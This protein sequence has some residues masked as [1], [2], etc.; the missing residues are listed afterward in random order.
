[1]GR[2]SHLE[3]EKNKAGHRR[4]LQDIGV[5]GKAFTTGSNHQLV[6]A[7]IAI[8]VKVEKRAL[9]TSNKGQQKTTL[10]SRTF[11]KLVEEEDWS[12]KDDISDDYNSLVDHLR[13]MQQMA[14]LPRANH[15]TKQI[16][17]A[18]KTLLEK[19]RQMKQ[20]GKDHI[21]YSLLCKL[22]QS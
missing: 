8:N 6:W 21:E 1:M 19:R 4:I 16:S 11:Q 14:E 2:Q 9:A 17:D 10:E 15:Q 7:K 12:I 22:I 5:V 13:A 18:T 3:L 20:D